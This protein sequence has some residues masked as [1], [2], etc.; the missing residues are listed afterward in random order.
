MNPGFVQNLTPPVIAAVIAASASVVVLGLTAFVTQVRYLYEKAREQETL[1]NALFGEMANVCE[2][3]M[4]VGAEAG[5]YAQDEL[6]LRLKLAHY[7]DVFALEE[8]SRYGFLDAADLRLLLQLS[9][10]IRNSDTT[11]DHL[12]KSAKAGKQVDHQKICERADLVVA[13]A[14]HLMK[15]LVSKRRRLRKIY[16]NLKSKSPFI[17]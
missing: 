2:H 6:V 3:Y 1:L 10:R 5:R 8:L 17:G 15:I 11:L 13:T 12:I 14:N 7:G 4:Y 9:L 16:A